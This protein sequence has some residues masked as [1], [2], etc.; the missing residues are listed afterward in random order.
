MNIRLGKKL[1]ELGFPEV[2]VEE[3]DRIEDVIFRGD[4]GDGYTQMWCRSDDKELLGVIFD[5][6]L[7]SM[8][9]WED[10]DGTAQ[11]VADAAE[12]YLFGF[13]EIRE[14]EDMPNTEYISL[15]CLTFGDD[16]QAAEAFERLRRDCVEARGTVITRAK[17]FTKNPSK[18]E[19]VFEES[20]VASYGEYT[21][22][23]AA[24]LVGSDILLMEAKSAVEL[25]IEM[26]NDLYL[27]SPFG[28]ETGEGEC[29]AEAVVYKL[30]T[31][32][33]T[34]PDFREAFDLLYPEDLLEEATKSM[35]SEFETPPEDF[36]LYKYLKQE[37]MNN[38]HGDNE[39]QYRFKVFAC[40]DASN[41]AVVNKLA[42]GNT[43][44]G[45]EEYEDYTIREDNRPE[46]ADPGVPIYVAYI[47]WGF[48]EDDDDEYTECEVL[49][50][51]LHNGRWF[52]DGKPL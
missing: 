51:Y 10:K 36:D 41:P 11:A 21:R 29:N 4:R 8:L 31:Y 42:N 3:D 40:E 22:S 35:L 52:V 39:R 6:F 12:R 25:I 15:C 28:T 23:M 19:I 24:Y 18:L 37:F 38:M 32:L 26:C 50:V 27:T 13:H 49:Y 1:D 9:V 7:D 44:A 17:Y 20:D 16:A 47:E 5:E 48:D 43:P 45:S 46:L 30:Y 14:D 34:K 2:E 33:L